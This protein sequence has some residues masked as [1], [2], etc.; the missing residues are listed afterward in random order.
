MFGKIQKFVSEV[1]VELKKV[2]WT[3]RGELIDA[4]WLVLV[5]SFFLGIAICGIDIILSQMLK[6]IIR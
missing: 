5:G 3:T 2:S 6:L 1:I 4:T